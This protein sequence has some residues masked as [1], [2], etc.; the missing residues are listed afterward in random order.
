IYTIT[1][2]DAQLFAYMTKELY[3]ERQ[4]AE[5]IRYTDYSL[6]AFD[7][8]H[9]DPNSNLD[10]QRSQE[11]ALLQLFGKMFNLNKQKLGDTDQNEA[12]KR[13]SEGNILV[14]DPCKP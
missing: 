11:S 14:E 12:V 4:I 13:D 5:N 1:I 7:N 10:I 2:K 6:E 8:L 3:G 9:G